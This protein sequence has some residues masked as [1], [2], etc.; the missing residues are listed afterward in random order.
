MLWG[1]TVPLS[2]VSLEWLGPGWLTV[3]RFAVEHTAGP[4][5]RFSVRVSGR[6]D[7]QDLRIASGATRYFWVEAAASNDV[8]IS[9]PDGNTSAQPGADPCTPAAGGSP[10]WGDRRMRRGPT[11][12]P[13]AAASPDTNA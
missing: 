5:T 1:L 7:G 4:D 11:A 6:A 13:G 8:E 3:A 2:K 9:W 10:P 12:T